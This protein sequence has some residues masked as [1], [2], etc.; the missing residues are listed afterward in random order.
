[1]NFFDTAINDALSQILGIKQKSHVVRHNLQF[2]A[3]YLNY[4][5]IYGL[6][7]H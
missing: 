5:S 3:T 4:Y 2:K 6:I 1:M 7:L